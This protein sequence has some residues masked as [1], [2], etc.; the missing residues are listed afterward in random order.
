MA[1]SKPKLCEDLAQRL[2][3]LF[4]TQLGLDRYLDLTEVVLVRNDLCRDFRDI[5][6][7]VDELRGDRVS[8]HLIELGLAWILHEGSSAILFYP[9]KTH[10]TVRAG[11]GEYDGYRSRTMRFGERP[12]KDIDGCPTLFDQDV[13]GYTEMSIEHHEMLI[14]GHDINVVRLYLFL[15][16]DLFDRH[17]GYRLENFRELTVMI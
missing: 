7:F 17:R 10:R 13:G 5:K 9:L 16:D 12:E 4:R 6:H 3:L 8:R 11:S 14:R 15:L 2:L 1:R